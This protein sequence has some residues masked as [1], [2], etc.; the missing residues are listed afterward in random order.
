[1]GDVF[2]I[3]GE[4]CGGSA[5]MPACMSLARVASCTRCNQAEGGYWIGYPA[6]LHYM[7]ISSH[8]TFDDARNGSHHRRSKFNPDEGTPRNPVHRRHPCPSVQIPPQRHG[9]SRT[10]TIS[11][12]LSLA[13][14]ITR[15]IRAR[16]GS[17]KASAVAAEYR[18]TALRHG[19]LTFLGWGL[20]FTPRYL[21]DIGLTRASR[22]RP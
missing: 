13:K 9:R 3:P 21:P 20:D 15:T 5:R 18:G 12:R 4:K 17:H 16:T 2:L 7:A 10:W 1:M 14:T 8:L 19:I 6:S 22:S 11:L